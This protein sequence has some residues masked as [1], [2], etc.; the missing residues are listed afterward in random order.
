VDAAREHRFVLLDLHAV[1]CHWCHVMDEKTYTDPTVRA[2]IGKRYVAVSVDADSDPALASRY[3][4]WGWPATIVLAADGTEIV[5]RRGFIP[6]EQMASLLQAIIDD[7]TPGPSVGAAPTAAAG[8]SVVSNAQRAAMRKIYDESYDAEHGGWGSGQ[9]FIDAPTME[10]TLM[11]V[12]DERDAV[13]ARRARQTLDANLRLI[14][15]VW[16][17]VYQYSESVDWASPHYEKLLAF[18][19]DDMRI[20]AEGYARWHDARYLKGVQA[21]QRYVA[22]FLTSPEGAF[23]V[24]QDADLSQT[25]TGQDYYGRGDA[26]RRQLGIP[27]V[28]SHEYARENGLGIRGLCKVYDVTGDATAL[29]AAVRAADW[30]LAHRALPGGGFRHDSKDSG[31][32]YLDD[33]LSMGQ[34]SLALY[35]SS[36][37]R[38]WLVHARAAMDYLARE[39]RDARGGFAAAPAPA[40][41][42]GVFRDP[43]RTIEENAG[44]AR[45]ANLLNRYTADARYRKLALHAAKFL[46][47]ATAALDAPRTEVLLTDRE[48]ATAPIHITV[49]G[50]KADPA[51]RALHA[52]ALGF[53][54]GYLQVDWWDRAEGPLPNPEIQYPT[55]PRAAAF[56]CTQ[57]T[58][59][60][61]VFEPQS[62]TA[63]VNAAL[64]E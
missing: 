7:P 40:G 11:L 51:A 36:G 59:S 57:G 50:G 14:D 58:C 47:A 62:I 24:S 39:F 26:A 12:V 31:G 30:A 33:T 49:V 20:Y 5:K 23:Y 32:P 27:R 64:Y 44:V 43:V 4:D 63:T 17:G 41:A 48:L 37:E 21:L 18:Q 15:P 28:D 53:P 2:L 35:R 42:T 25:V 22:M 13:A 1:W 19:A 52:A 6:P 9:K 3:G 56:A 45:F 54:A 34:A 61:P 46:A 38:R 55:L 16:G 29:A 8:S 10:Y 60:N